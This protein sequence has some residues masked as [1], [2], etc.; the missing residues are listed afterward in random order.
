MKNNT[1]NKIISIVVLVAL[2]GAT[3]FGAYAGLMGLNTKMVTVKENGT[4]VQKALYRIVS[5]IPNTLNNSWQEAIQPD[6]TLG[7]GYSYVLTAPD[8]VK[9][10]D[11]KKAA[12]VIRARADMLVGGAVTKVEGSTLTL[13]VPGKDYDASIAAVLQPIGQ[14]TFAQYDED[15]GLFGAALLDGSITDGTY[16]YMGENGYNIQLH[17]TAKGAAALRQVIAEHAFEYLYLLLDGEP[18]GY[19]PLYDGIIT[20]SSTVDFMAPDASS[21]F[22]TAVAMRAA[23]LPCVLTLTSDGVAAASSSLMNVGIIVFAC[24]LLLACVYM[25]ARSVKAGLLGAWALIAGVV[26]AALLNAL[27]VVNTIWVVTVLSGIVVFLCLTVM[28]CSVVMVVNKAA[29]FVRAG[30][31][32]AASVSAAIG[33]NGKLV[34]LVNGVLMAIGLLMMFAFQRNAVGIMGRVVAADALVTLVMVFIFLPVVTA[35]IKSLRK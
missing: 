15:T 28:A 21:A 10:E 1:V 13:T 34:A 5:F 31:E 29:G 9:A 17:L 3:V 6:T 25:I 2:L 27:I 22:V 26:L 32:T 14:A 19:S 30:R 4:D 11:M 18:V 8:G 16:Y 12:E 24:L 33:K 23:S 35:C 7:G 20:E